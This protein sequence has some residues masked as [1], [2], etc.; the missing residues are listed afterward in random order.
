MLLPSST[1]VMAPLAVGRP[2]ASGRSSIDWLRAAAIGSACTVPGRSVPARSVGVGPVLRR[3]RHDL[4]VADREHAPRLVKDGRSIRIQM[5]EA[6]PGPEHLPL[7]IEGDD[8]FADPRG[9]VAA[10][11]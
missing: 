4:R 7:A 11:R 5:V 9:G 1:D 3:R 2:S 8:H 10:V 6:V